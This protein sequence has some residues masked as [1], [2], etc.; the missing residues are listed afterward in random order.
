[1]FSGAKNL[2][3]SFKKHCRVRAEKLQK[4]TNA[5]DNDDVSSYNIGKIS[6]YQDGTIERTL[7][8]MIGT[9]EQLSRN[10]NLFRRHVA[11]AKYE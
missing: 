7:D 2:L 6:D 9:G 11:R 4:M 8:A 3:N 1:M 5:I 10:D